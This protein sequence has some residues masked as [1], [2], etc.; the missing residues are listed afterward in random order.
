M[1]KRGRPPKVKPDPMD[2][3]Q[4][5]DEAVEPKV[6]VPAQKDQYI[7]RSKSPFTLCLQI[8]KDEPVRQPNGTYTTVQ[9]KQKVKVK[10]DDSLHTLVVSEALATALD[11]TVADINYHLK[12]WPSYNREFVLVSAPGYKPSEAVLLFDRNSQKTVEMKKGRRIIQGP[13]SSTNVT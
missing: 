10:F 3:G 7:Y 5:I 6:E 4:P 9:I 8:P 2:S 1:A 11:T 12:K 13:K